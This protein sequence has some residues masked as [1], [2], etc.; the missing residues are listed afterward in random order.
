MPY[1]DHVHIRA[2]D[3]SR[4]I[5]F[6]KAYFEACVIQE[7]E[8]LGRKITVL[9]IGNKSKLSILHQAPA[10][11]SPKH[12]QASIDHIAI[13]VTNIERLV[14]RLKEEGFHFPVDVTRAST[15]A[16]IAFCLGPDNVYL[17]IFEREAD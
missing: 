17:E 10:V 3:P 14:S 11:E 2:S 12:E 13:G 5:E 4:T 6:F 9:S 15:G 16:K 1:I 8:N 7:F